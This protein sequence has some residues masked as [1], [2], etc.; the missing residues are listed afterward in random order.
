MPDP[1]DPSKFSWSGLMNS[2]TPGPQ[3]RGFPNLGGALSY[4][5]SPR[6]RETFANTQ[7]TGLEQSRSGLMQSSA[8]RDYIQ[9]HYG[10]LTSTN[11]DM[12]LAIAHAHGAGSQAALQ[13]TEA[14][15]A[16][17]TEAGQAGAEQAYRSTQGDPYL[18][19]L[20][21]GIQS[22]KAGAAKIGAEAQL[23]GVEAGAAQ[24]QFNRTGTTPQ[25]ELSREQLAQQRALAGSELG[26]KHME[27]LK[28]LPV[29][30]LKAISGYGGIGM[31]GGPGG[32]EDLGEMFRSALKN[33]GVQGGQPQQKSGG[34]G[35]HPIEEEFLRGKTLY[36]RTQPEA[37]PGTGPG[38]TP[39]AI[40][41]DPRLDAPWANGVK[42]PN[43]QG[44]DQ[45]ILNRIGGPDLVNKISLLPPDKA[46]AMIQQLMQ[47]WYQ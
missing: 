10:D 44:I 32:M 14:A 43:I 19:Q 38:S 20:Q 18:A 4:T 17:R 27:F 5:T 28:T 39:R 7:Q 34:P 24:N 46:K 22:Q 12:A 16:G 21:S 33:V 8:L 47:R 37:R 30:V 41:A 25:V 26:E 40:Y 29:D 6:A 23:T 42:S 2:M 35:T 13:A 1:S 31:M 9:K 45:L 3:S 11:P 15:T 36:P